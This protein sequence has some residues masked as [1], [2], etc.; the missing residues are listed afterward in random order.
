M[1]R[2]RVSLTSGDR[3][4]PL[5]E[6]PREAGSRCLGSAVRRRR[7]RSLSLWLVDL[8]PPAPQP[9]T[10]NK[11]GKVRTRRHLIPRVQRHPPSLLRVLRRRQFLRRDRRRRASLL[12]R[13]ALRLRPKF[14]SQPRRAPRRRSRHHTSRDFESVGQRQALYQSRYHRACKGI[15]AERQR[16]AAAARARQAGCWKRGGCDVTE[17]WSGGSCSACGACPNF[18]NSARR[19]GDNVAR[20]G[21]ACDSNRPA[22]ARSLRTGVQRTANR[23]VRNAFTCGLHTPREFV[24]KQSS[25]RTCQTSEHSASRPQSWHR[26]TDRRLANKAGSCPKTLWRFECGAQVRF[27]RARAE[28]D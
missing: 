24:T 27:C 4:R 26:S 14:V 18:A 10:F 25:V 9:A 11:S 1:T 7:R 2:G 22:A 20:C 17:A 8:P 16:D 15:A 5:L 3:F 21:H 12:R 13:R 28:S 23:R 6:V 19:S